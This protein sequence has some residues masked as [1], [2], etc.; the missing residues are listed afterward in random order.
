MAER[1]AQFEAVCV[2]TQV[3]LRSATGFVPKENGFSATSGLPTFQEL[4]NSMADRDRTA[5]E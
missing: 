4:A 5:D 2:L 3:T 1:D